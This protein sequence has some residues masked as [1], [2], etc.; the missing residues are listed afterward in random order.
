[1]LAKS[2]WLKS[3]D[4]EKRETQD[5]HPSVRYDG[6]RYYQKNDQTGRKI[7]PG[8]RLCQD[9]GAH[10]PEQSDEENWQGDCRDNWIRSMGWQRQLDTE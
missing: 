1:M 10:Q 2:K 3:K 4:I 7:H 5:F 6:D 8:G 9:H